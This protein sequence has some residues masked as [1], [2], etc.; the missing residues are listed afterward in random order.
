[1]GHERLGA[2]PRTRRWQTI[3]DG[4]AA[5]QEGGTQAVGDLAERTLENVEDRFLRIHKDSGVQAAFAYLISL[6]TAS[7]P[8]SGGLASPDTRIECDL[9]PA[10]IAKNLCDWV[11][12]HGSS[13]EY[14]EIAC[15]AGADTIAQWTR[16]QSE[17]GRLFDD[18]SDAAQ[19]WGKS[20]DGASFCQIARTFFARFTE[21]YLRYFLERHAS[22]QLSSVSARERFNEHLHEHV[23]EVSHHAFEI[24]EITQSFAAGWFNKHAVQARPSDRE[25]EGFLAVAF[26]K[27]REELKRETDR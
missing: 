3:V 7:L 11:R 14:A 27:L 22:S 26:G 13:P 24:A 20:S 15:R 6:A 2:L 23:D 10:R 8:P 21:R 25:I 12:K 9:S 18:R 5:S 16:K 1:M 19:I 4:I 17:Q